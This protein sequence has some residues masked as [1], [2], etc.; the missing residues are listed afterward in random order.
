MIIKF[1]DF[2]DYCT[3]EMKPFFGSKSR[4]YIYLITFSNQ[5]TFGPNLS[6]PRNVGWLVGTMG[7][8]VD[9]FE[10]STYKVYNLLSSLQIYIYM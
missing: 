7:S 3:L 10:K 2:Q 5:P 8:I 4:K 1:W 6:R 9:L